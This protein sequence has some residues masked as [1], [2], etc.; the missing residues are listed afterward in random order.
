MKTKKE[1]K[2][3]STMLSSGDFVPGGRIIYGSGRNAGKHNL[4][5]CYVII[6][7]IVSIALEKLFR[8]C[9]KFHVLVVVLV[10]MYL[11]FV[12]K[13]M[14]SNVKNSGQCFCSQDD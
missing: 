1:S 2:V 14:I 12:L 5:N 8:T 13:A 11:R 7:R 3:G 10:L 4:L 6:L 9:T